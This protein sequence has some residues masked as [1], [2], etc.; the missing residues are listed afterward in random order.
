MHSVSVSPDA[1]VC[2]SSFHTEHPLIIICTTSMQDMW[3]EP[4]AAIFSSIWT[5]MLSGNCPVALHCTPT[6]GDD[7]EGDNVTEKTEG[8]SSSPVMVK[9]K[10]MRSDRCCIVAVTGTAVG[11]G[12][13][14][15]GRLHLL[16]KGRTRQDIFVYGFCQTI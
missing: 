9:G 6:Y 14:S 15:K 11:P 1:V 4:I 12:F 8:S 3:A 16:P 7:P 13:V 10:A 2:T 5:F